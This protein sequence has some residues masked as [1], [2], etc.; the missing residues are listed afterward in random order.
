MTP[1]TNFADM[2]EQMENNLVVHN[3]DILNGRLEVDTN[4]GRFTWQPQDKPVQDAESGP[5]QEKPEGAG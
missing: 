4:L 1:F 5:S 3:L 2:K